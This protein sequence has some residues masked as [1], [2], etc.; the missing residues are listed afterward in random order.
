MWAE[1]A[2]IK[3][4]CLIQLIL[5]L[6]EGYIRQISNNVSSILLPTNPPFTIFLILY[7][8]VTETDNPSEVRKYS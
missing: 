3:I 7:K 2:R 6:I 5:K 1:T 4:Y 8:A